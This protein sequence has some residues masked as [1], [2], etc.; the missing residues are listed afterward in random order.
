MG[1]LLLIYLGQQQQLQLVRRHQIV[2]CQLQRNPPGCWQKQRLTT[3][4]N[5]TVKPVL[6]VKTLNTDIVVFKLPCY[7]TIEVGIKLLG[8]VV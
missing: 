5:N 2:N 1:R 3:L 8:W 4:A 7:L 6:P